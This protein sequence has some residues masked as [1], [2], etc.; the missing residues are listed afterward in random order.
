[1]EVALAEGATEPA[2]SE[3]MRWRSTGEHMCPVVDSL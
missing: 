1:M 2:D 3:R